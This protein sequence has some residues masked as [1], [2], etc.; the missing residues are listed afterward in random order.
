MAFPLKFLFVLS[1]ITLITACGGGSGTDDQGAGLDGSISSLEN[2][3][4][5]IPDGVWLVEHQFESSSSTNGVVSQSAGVSWSTAE[6]TTVNNAKRLA[7]CGREPG[8]MRDP[9]PLFI[10]GS[11]LWD[12]NAD[13]R[14]SSSSDEIRIV[15][16]DDNQLIL[17]PLPNGSMSHGSVTVTTSNSAQGINEPNDACLYIRDL[18]L[19]TSSN[20]I[21]SVIHNFT[22]SVNFP[23]N[24]SFSQL[25]LTQLQD[26]PSTGELS[27]F[28]P[29]EASVTAQGEGFDGEFVDCNLFP[30]DED[31]SVTFTQADFLNVEA[32]FSC[33]DDWGDGVFSVT[34]AMNASLPN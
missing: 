30:L 21:S 17:T 15:Q 25:T 32:S 7:I 19:T 23:I 10:T 24:N 4:E 2:L 5:N 34:G 20:G 26:S 1:V 3:A 8:P 29:S 33:S 9:T 28:S 31:G 13:Y 14:V 6:V 27:L 11:F 22:Y 18:T 16:D 12:F